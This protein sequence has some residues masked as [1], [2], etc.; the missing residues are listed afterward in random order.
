MKKKLKKLFIFKNQIKY[1]HKIIRAKDQN[2]FQ[3]CLCGKSNSN[4]RV[5]CSNKS[6]S[7]FLG[8][9]LIN[10]VWIEV[11]LPSVLSSLFDTL[12]S[13]EMRVIRL[14]EMFESLA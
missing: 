5:F 4:P 12:V 2:L 13:L 7:K 10:L 3:K 14:F 9:L 6:C 11:S 8:F 1:K